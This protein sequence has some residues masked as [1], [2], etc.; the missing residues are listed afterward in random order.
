VRLGERARSLWATLDQSRHLAPGLLDYNFNMLMSIAP[1][2]ILLTNG[3][4]D[5]YPALLLQRTRA[6]HIVQ[7]NPHLLKNVTSARKTNGDLNARR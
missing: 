3:D 6:L 2:A 5:T 1:D 7:P 4:N